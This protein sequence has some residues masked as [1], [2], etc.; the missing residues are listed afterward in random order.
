MTGHDFCWGSH[1]CQFTD[2]DHEGDHVCECG[3]VYDETWDAYGDDA[4]AAKRD[5]LMRK[6]GYDPD[7]P[8]RGFA[9]GEPPSGL[10]N[11]VC[12]LEGFEIDGHRDSDHTG[13][14]MFCGATIE[15]PTWS[16]TFTV[17]ELHHHDGQPN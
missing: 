12:E 15:E 16:M 3:H 14:C 9:H 17:T 13:F 10:R 8:P 7:L 11:H 4:D 2:A 6:H 1:G 5:H